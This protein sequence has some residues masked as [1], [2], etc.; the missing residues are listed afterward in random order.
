MVAPVPAIAQYTIG[1]TTS[2]SKGTGHINRSTTYGGN[3]RNGTTG[4]NGISGTNSGNGSNGSQF[5]GYPIGTSSGT[6]NGTTYYPGSNPVWGLGG[7]PVGSIGFPTADI[8]QF[9]FYNNSALGYYSANPM[10]GQYPVY[11]APVSLGD[12][13]YAFGGM[14]SRMGYW[15][16][17]SG[18][19]Y[20][21]C[22]P[23][24]LPG[25]AYSSS[26]PIYMMDQGNLVPAKPSV[27]TVISD[28]R[29]FID[30]AKPKKQLDQS[31]YEYVFNTLNQISD[32]TDALSAKNSGTLDPSDETTLRR[33]L[34]LLGADIARSL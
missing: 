24:Y 34:D 26:A 21:W 18:Y 27:A 25:V 8:A 11:P 5:R 13:Y 16:A 12:S 2:E 23:V 4:I 14:N 32:R 15:R 19:Y 33:D 31:T 3:A 6:D 20:P 29:Q 28:M 17:A 30:D 10:M 1:T 22:S 9:G 7:M